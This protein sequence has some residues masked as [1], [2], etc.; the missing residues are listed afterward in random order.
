MQ[1]PKKTI[2]FTKE[3]YQSMQDK[4]AGLL[5]LRVE[6]MERLITAREMGDLS[7]NGAYKYAKFELGNIGRELKKYQGLLDSG[8]I[9]ERS[10]SSQTI[11]VFGSIVTLARTDNSDKIQTFTVVSKHES[12]PVEGL[13]SF[14]SPMGKAVMRKKQGETIIVTTPRGEVS[15]R[16]ITVS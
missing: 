14:S 16:I 12:N 8:F 15:Y 3:K 7:E 1:I 6:V 4:V 13:L 11:I 2:P 5:A 10:S 9:R